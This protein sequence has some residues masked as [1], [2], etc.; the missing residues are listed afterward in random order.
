MT[1]RQFNLPQGF[2]GEVRASASGGGVPR[3]GCHAAEDPSSRVGVS[4]PA[5]QKQTAGLAGG[6]RPSGSP[7]GDALDQDFTLHEAAVTL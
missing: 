2:L 1:E 5:S 3:G 6:G 4:L 7:P